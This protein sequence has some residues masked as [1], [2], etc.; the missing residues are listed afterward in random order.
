MLEVVVMNVNLLGGGGGGG[1]GDGWVSN[2]MWSFTQPT[3]SQKF[4]RNRELRDDND[5]T[6]SWIWLSSSTRIVGQFSGILNI[7]SRRYNGVTITT[8]LQNPSRIWSYHKILL[9]DSDE[10]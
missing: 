5:V 7:E 8:Q 2:Y 10:T 1:G 9:F 3:M 6:D 4:L